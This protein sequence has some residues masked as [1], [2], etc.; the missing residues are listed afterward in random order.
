MLLTGFRLRVAVPLSVA[1]ATTFLVDVAL[2]RRLSPGAWVL[3]RGGCPRVFAVVP[4]AQPGD[5]LGDAQLTGAC[6]AQLPG[7]VQ[8]AVGQAVLPVPGELALLVL[9]DGQ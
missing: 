8:Q 5:A 4:V 6:G 1:F 3:S 2:G 9:E 7:L